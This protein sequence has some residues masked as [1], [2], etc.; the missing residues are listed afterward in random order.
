MWLISIYPLKSFSHQIFFII[1][2]LLIILCKIDFCL[3]HRCSLLKVINQN[4]NL[5]FHEIYFWFE[6]LDIHMNEKTITCHDCH[7]FK[8][9]N[10]NIYPILIN[11]LCNLTP[12]LACWTVT[13]PIWF[14]FLWKF[15][16]YK[17]W[18]LITSILFFLICFDVW[19][20]HL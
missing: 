16:R 17:N 12:F 11:F 14:V 18:M 19:I 6:F 20:W 8:W 7:G 10:I 9:K 15:K 5:K 1:W 2:V 4:L 3:T 13:T